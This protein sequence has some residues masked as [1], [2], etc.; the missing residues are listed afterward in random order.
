M[1]PGL[2]VHNLQGLERLAGR[3]EPVTIK[4]PMP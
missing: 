2:P 4:V 3:E 1:H